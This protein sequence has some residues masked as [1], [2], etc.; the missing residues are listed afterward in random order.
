MQKHEFHGLS[1]TPEYNAYRA[2]KGRC[3]NPNCE[4][5]CWYGERGIQFKFKS[6]KQFLQELGKRPSTEHSLDR[7]NVNGH[8]ETGNVRWATPIEQAN[9]R[10]YGDRRGE[11][12]GRAKLTAK[13]AQQVRSLLGKKSGSTVA[14]QFQISET[15]VYNI[16]HDRV[17]ND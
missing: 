2:A 17:W 13:T 9:N 8:Y 4:G 1:N 16:W 15:Q 5:Y 11:K 6:F 3:R 14:K 7:I 12:N 10:R